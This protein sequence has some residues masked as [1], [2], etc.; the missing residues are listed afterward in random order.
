MSQLEGESFHVISGDSMPRQ[1]PGR[2]N[3]GGKMLEMVIIRLYNFR[4]K[5]DKIITTHNKH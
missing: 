3:I 2:R 4:N 5:A 1:W